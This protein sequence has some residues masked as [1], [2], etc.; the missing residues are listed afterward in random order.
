MVCHWS[1]GGWEGEEVV[2]VVVEV[3][4]V[5]V[6]EEEE[7]EV[8]EGRFVYTPPPSPFWLKIG[9]DLIMQLHK[10]DS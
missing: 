10:M 9:R 4:V 2:V 8:E 3:V 5:V 1:F 6:E 7:E